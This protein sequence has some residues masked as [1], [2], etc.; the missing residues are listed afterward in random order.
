MLS[1][2][3]VGELTMK[4]KLCGMGFLIRVF[5]LRVQVRHLRYDKVINIAENVYTLEITMQTFAI[6]AV[7]TSQWWPQLK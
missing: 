6:V 3:L 7:E 4:F 1:V 5:A 2:F